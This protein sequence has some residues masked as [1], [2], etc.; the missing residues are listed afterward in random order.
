MIP[1]GLQ[2]LVNRTALPDMAEVRAM[3]SDASDA[4]HELWKQE[5]CAIDSR[6]DLW[7]APLGQVCVPDAFLPVPLNYINSLTHAGKKGTARMVKETW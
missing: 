7:L 2:I 5:G 4:Q 3:Q 1:V 6:T